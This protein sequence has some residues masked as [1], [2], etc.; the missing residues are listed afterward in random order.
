MRK[1]Q[2]KKFIRNNSVFRIG[3]I[4]VKN[5]DG[6]FDIKSK[7]RSEAYKKINSSNIGEV[8]NFQVGQSINILHIEGD[9]QKPLILTGGEYYSDSDIIVINI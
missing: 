1:S 3:I 5:S 6:S 4:S 8:K 7:G 2:L 9:S